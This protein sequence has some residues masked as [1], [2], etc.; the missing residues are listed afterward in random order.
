M[1]GFL[2]MATWCGAVFTLGFY[3]AYIFFCLM[4]LRYGWAS[5]SEHSIVNG[6][7]YTMIYI[8]HP[9]FRSRL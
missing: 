4:A 5:L 1:E 6:N 8:L 9:W 3:G 2:S 7:V